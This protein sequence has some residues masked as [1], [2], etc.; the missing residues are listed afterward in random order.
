LT[1]TRPD[2][3]RD[4]ATATPSGGRG[5]STSASL[6]REVLER[7]AA[8]GAGLDTPAGRAWGTFLQ[9][10]ASLTRVLDT[11]LRR[12]ADLS[13]SD[14]DVLMQLALG[15][16]TLRMGELARA[17]LLSRSGMTRRVEQLERRGLVTRTT[18]ESDGRSVR[19][20]LTLTGTQLFRGA[21]DVHAAG[22][23]AHFVSRLEPDDAPAL[24]A[25]LQK[26][27]VDCDFG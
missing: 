26:V 14:F 27:V 5:A 8:Q 12:D 4:A 20:S 1:T 25:V 24:R 6:R 9:A 7:S 15:N 18:A 2:A 19:V 23:A 10:H 17:T 13:L 11:E 21:L 3:A 16:G 22:I